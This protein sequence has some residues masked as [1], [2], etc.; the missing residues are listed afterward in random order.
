MFAGYLLF[1]KLFNYTMNGI[2]SS[3]FYSVLVVLK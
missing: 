1:K 2:L 3:L